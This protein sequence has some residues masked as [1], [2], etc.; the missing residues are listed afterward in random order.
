M[1]TC[2]I[3]R[4][5]VL[6]AM[7]NIESNTFDACLTDPPYALVGGSRNGSSQPG[8]MSTPQGRSGPSKK[9]GFMGLEWDGEIPSVEV[10]AELLR[11]LKPGGLLLAFGGTRTW[12][13]LA[14]NIE[15]AGFN[16]KDTLMY[17]YG[18]GF[19]KSHAIGKAID[20]VAGAER[21]VTGHSKNGS[22]ASQIK[23]SNHGHGDTG[24]GM[25]DGSGKEFDVTEP[26]TDEAKQWDG[27]GTGLKPAFEPILLCQAPVDKTYAN[28][29]LT[30][31]CG[32]LNIDG[33][34][35]ETEHNQERHSE[36][37][38]IYGGNALL[39][40][41]T[42][43]TTSRDGD[44]S[45]RWP[46][47][48]ILDE[49]SAEQ[50]DKQSGELKSG[51]LKPYKQKNRDGYSGS[52]PEVRLYNCPASMGG[53][54][55]F[56]YCAK[57]SRSERNKGLEGLTEKDLYWSSGKQSPGTFQSEG[58]NKKAQNNHPTL[59]PIAL[60][61][62]LAKLILP[63]ER[64]TPRK[65]IVPFSGAGSEMIGA[66]RAGWDEATGIELMA[67]YVEIAK[68][69]IE[70]DAPMFNQVEIMAGAE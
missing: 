40:S 10:W 15:D 67:E 44:P 43:Q 35:I 41:S 25:L 42:K 64:D 1:S 11:V 4:G 17:L 70:S 51:E 34:R 8:D 59:K 12:H 21:T 31:G 18:S 66:L 14:V 9:R 33:S 65:I 16:I 6:D 13:R 38:T 48:L 63:P 60:T 57:V 30:W 7:K 23:L 55:R 27:Y 68:L 54:S 37:K 3:I 2:E 32:G 53:A 61:E 22:G 19:P 56:F 52:M 5:D 62:Y 47:N 24:I 20:K 45:G 69:R 46:A 39:Q 29:A 36:G 49:Q 28:N 58:T 26:A 50:L